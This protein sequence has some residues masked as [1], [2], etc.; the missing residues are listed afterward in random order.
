M[1]NELEIVIDGLSECYEEM[2]IDFEKAMEEEIKQ[3]QL[4]QLAMTVPEFPEL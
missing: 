4:R 3:N 1:D 2:R